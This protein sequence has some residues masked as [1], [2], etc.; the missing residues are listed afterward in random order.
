MSRAA[1]IPV[2]SM[3]GF[4]RARRPL[5]DAELVVTLK[6]VNHRALDLH[7]HTGPEFDPFESAMRSA[8]KRHVTRG[9]LSIRIVVERP[10]GAG[11]LLLDSARLAG[12]MA[13]FREGSKQYGLVGEPDLNVAFTIPGILA[14]TASTDLPA[15]FEPALLGALEEALVMLNEFRARE[16]G[17]LVALLRRHN[18]AVHS[19]A[20]RIEEIRS[21]ALAAFQTRLQERLA[22][23][24]AGMNL[25]P[26]RLAQEAAILADR[27]DIGEETA[28]LKIHS[29]QLDEILE[30]GGEVGK[31]L[32]FLLQEM[33][34]E[35]NTILSKTSGIGEAGLGI[36]DL[37]LA[38]KSDI[39][40]IREQSLN[41][42]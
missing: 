38:A 11:G 41:L 21:R 29:R 27:S 25:D 2:R 7:F 28:R 30:G 22:E 39:E 14:E 42:E 34:R 13:A 3:T 18:E 5:G 8:I 24:L 6:S 9:H 4:A 40:K 33:N 26:Q 10:G 31:K 36:S 16:G 1:S 12:Y 20:L 23:L 15:E 19:A 35:T 37:A 32:D 17:E